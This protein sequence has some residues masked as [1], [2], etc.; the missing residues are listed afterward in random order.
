MIQSNVWFERGIFLSIV[1]N[2]IVLLIK[3]YRM[4]DFFLNVLENLN[5]LF[6]SVFTLEAVIKIIGLGKAYF[7]DG[8]NI[9]DFLIVVFSG[10]SIILSQV[11][12]IN[13]VKGAITVIRS[14]RIM[15]I[16][17]LVKRAKSLRL[18]FS[19]LI[20][21]LPGL[22]NVGGLLSLLLYL[23]AVLGTFL[24]AT[25]KRNGFL[26]EMVNFETFGNS[27]VT[28]FT[29]ATAETFNP[30]YLATTRTY[31]IDF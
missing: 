5:Y 2:T 24:F 26:D 18:V 27:F 7:K 10:L 19:T 22:V 30:V 29:A 15:R 23:Y 13:N 8:W 17:R 1:L 21:S 12:Q 6:T 28:L 11:T 25:V 4:S 20:V 16:L 14:F 31:S 9:F 3:Y